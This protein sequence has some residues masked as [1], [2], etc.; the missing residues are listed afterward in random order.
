MDSMNTLAAAGDV[1]F[2]GI[3]IVIGIA[4]AAFVALLIAFIIL[5]RRK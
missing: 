3:V 5:R 2:A 1:S 4:A